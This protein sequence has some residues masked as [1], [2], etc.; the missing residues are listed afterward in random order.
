MA[1]VSSAVRPI[2]RNIR[3]GVFFCLS[4]SEREETNLN[5]RSDTE[6][7]LSLSQQPQ[8]LRFPKERVVLVLMI[9][10]FE[11]NPGQIG[12]LV[13]ML[14][15]YCGDRC[16]MKRKKEKPCQYFERDSAGMGQA[17]ENFPMVEVTWRAF[18]H[19]EAS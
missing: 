19:Y 3:S 17:G 1:T 5:S 16:D 18:F 13:C 6:P 2:T 8:G 9:V 15:I 12:R 4:Q 11:R 10:T 14:L 7:S